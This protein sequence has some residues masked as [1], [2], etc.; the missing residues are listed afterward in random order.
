[1]TETK[2]KIRKRKGEQKFVTAWIYNDVAEK[3]ANEVFIKHRAKS[4]PEWIRQAIDEK[5]AKDLV[6]LATAPEPA[7]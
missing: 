2:P 5:L 4:M 1:M 7:N 6:E 3:V